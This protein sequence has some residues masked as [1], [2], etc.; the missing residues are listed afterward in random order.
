MRRQLED[1][2]T[3]VLQ[4]DCVTQI[5][6]VTVKN[7]CLANKRRKGIYY[8]M[9]FFVQVFDQYLNFISLEENMFTTRYQERDAISY[10]GELK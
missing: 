2:A 8:E 7:I 4:G 9:L 5:S 1:L 3:A 6:K 10:Y